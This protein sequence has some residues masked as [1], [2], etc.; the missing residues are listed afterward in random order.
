MIQYKHRDKQKHIQMFSSAN[1]LFHFI[2]LFSNQRT[3]VNMNH[4]IK[5]IRLI[6]IL[7]IM[8]H[9]RFEC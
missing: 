5:T 7:I 6:Y 2:F 4:S 9:C 8:K 1:A 3:F